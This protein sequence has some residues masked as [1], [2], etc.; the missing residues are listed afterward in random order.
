MPRQA[1]DGHR[2]NGSIRRTSRLR[3]ALTEGN[4]G[5]NTN[6]GPALQ[7]L[8]FSVFKD[9]AFTERFRLQF[10][11]EF[12]NIFNTAQF[13]FPDSGYG[14]ANFGKVTSTLPGTERH[15]QFCL[16]FLF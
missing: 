13:S 10:R 2:R 3:R 16:K 9:F 12:F 8:D 5:D 15:V 6:S 1:G 7:N 4:V 11:S 14:D